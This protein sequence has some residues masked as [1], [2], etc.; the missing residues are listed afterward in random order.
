[1]ASGHIPDSSLSASSYQTEYNREPKYARLGGKSFWASNESDND[2]WIQV[3]LGSIHNV[4]GL[5]TEGNDDG[6][7]FKYWV[8]KIM[9][10][11]GDSEEN[12]EFI[13]QTERNPK[14]KVCIQ[15]IK[16][17]K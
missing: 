14:P 8:K 3:D 1:M 13:N 5:K 2:T 12:L 4:T 9:V 16:E 10:K 15:C 6:P 7:N 17:K 11:Y